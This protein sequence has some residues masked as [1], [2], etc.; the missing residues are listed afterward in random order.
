MGLA[1]R[2][3]VGAVLYALASLCLL[4]VMISFVIQG[5]TTKGGGISNI[6]HSITSAGAVF[7]V[8]QKKGTQEAQV[9]TAVGDRFHKLEVLASDH[10]SADDD[11]GVRSPREHGHGCANDHGSTHDD[12][13]G[14][15]TV[16]NDVWRAAHLLVT[17]TSAGD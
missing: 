8:Q 17:G 9:V 10:G 1:N 6:I 11:S 16:G 7:M 2:R 3:I 5:F 14:R 15:S 4:F 12:R 13:S